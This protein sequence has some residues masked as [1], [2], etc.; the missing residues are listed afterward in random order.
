[1]TASCINSVNGT[2]KRTSAADKPAVQCLITSESFLHAGTS[3]VRREMDCS[4]ELRVQTFSGAFFQSANPF[5]G[6]RQPPMRVSARDKR[7]ACA[8]FLNASGKST[9]NHPFSSHNPCALADQ[10]NPSRPGS[11]A[12]R[13]SFRFTNGPGKKK[14]GPGRNPPNFVETT[15]EEEKHHKWTVM[16]R[17]PTELR[18]TSGQPLGVAPRADADRGLQCFATVEVRV[19]QTRCIGL[20]FAGVGANRL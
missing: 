1:M 16:V 2:T 5:R 3:G 6:N 17:R 20:S 4:P 19:E 7:F 12:V 11:Q 18:T 10:A 13:W 15:K 14:T 8:M 9:V